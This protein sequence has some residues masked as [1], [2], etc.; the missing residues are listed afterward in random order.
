MHYCV[1]T[2]E[3]IA[4][5][6]PASPQKPSAASGTYW[7]AYGMPMNLVIQFWLD[8]NWLLDKSR[9]CIA[10]SRA[11]T[12]STSVVAGRC[13][14]RGCFV[15]SASSSSRSGNLPDCKLWWPLLEDLHSKINFFS[16]CHFCQSLANTGP[17]H[18]AMTG[19]TFVAT[20][21]CTQ[22]N[23]A[24]KAILVVDMTHLWGCCT[25]LGQGG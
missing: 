3:H 19:C 10:G 22:N 12:L 17:R 18:A 9:L 15:Q 24:L 16:F 11:F 1:T 13:F 20:L 4:E 25:I 5:M 2:V 23:F 7:N 21:F 6:I 8:S 14:T